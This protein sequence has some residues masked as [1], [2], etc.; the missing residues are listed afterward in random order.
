MP[1]RQASCE[2][3]SRDD[4]RSRCK[5]TR[6]KNRNWTSIENW[7]VWE[8]GKSVG[9]KTLNPNTHSGYLS[10]CS[11]RRKKIYTF[12]SVEVFVILLS[13]RIEADGDIITCCQSADVQSW[14]HL[15]QTAW[16]L[17]C[18]KRSPGILQTGTCS[19]GFSHSRSSVL[20]KRDIVA[21]QLWRRHLRSGCPRETGLTSQSRD[22]GLQA[23][24]WP[25]ALLS[26]RQ[27]AEKK[28]LQTIEVRKSPTMK[29]SNMPDLSHLS[30][31]FVHQR[32]LR[33]ALQLQG[34]LG[35]GDTT[36]RKL[37]NYWSLEPSLSAESHN[38]LLPEGVFGVVQQEFFGHIRAVEPDCAAANTRSHR[39]R[40]ASN[41]DTTTI[42]Q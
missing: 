38:V 35:R 7:P 12:I 41:S 23:A 4:W 32:D 26:A 9:H 6:N 40:L 3:H 1:F 10:L 15:P 36:I 17:P 21:L 14:K 13:V 11:D 33:G 25:Q 28:R 37:E 19:T 16:S 24:E 2:T 20:H 22:N 29:L 8:F 34:N 30:G 31:C 39:R 27:A 5:N 42:L 18:T